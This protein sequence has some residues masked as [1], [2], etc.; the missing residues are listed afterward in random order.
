MSDG[1]KEVKKEADVAS[2]ATEVKTVV[3]D[4][5]PFVTDNDTFDVRVRYYK[6]N[7][8]I[9]AEEV[10]EDFD[11]DNKGIKTLSLTIKYP[12]QGDAFLINSQS[13][14]SNVESKNLSQINAIADYLQTEVIRLLNLVRKWDAKETLSNESVLSLHPKVVK[15]ILGKVR[16]EIGT[17][18]IV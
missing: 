17:D 11:K 16:D 10:D 8:K 18:G 3:V 7:K 2:V 5:S 13:K 14:Q 1:V 6:V 12:S 9:M 15:A 4:D